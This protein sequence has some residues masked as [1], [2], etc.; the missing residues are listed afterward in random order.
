MLAAAMAAVVIRRTKM[1]ALAARHGILLR[2]PLR[3]R[4]PA[5]SPLLRRDKSAEAAER[6]LAQDIPAVLAVRQVK[7]KPALTATPQKRSSPKSEAVVALVG[8][9][10]LVAQA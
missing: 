10:L 1:V 6:E 5:V 9:E 2:A 3:I 8:M 4:P 7:R